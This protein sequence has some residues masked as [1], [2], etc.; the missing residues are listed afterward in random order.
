MSSFLSPP[1]SF[2]RKKRKLGSGTG[3]N[4]ALANVPENRYVGKNLKKIET[5]QEE[6][7]NTSS[8]GED[9]TSKRSTRSSAHSSGEDETSKRSTRSSAHSSGEDETSKRSTRSSVTTQWLNPVSPSSLILAAKLF[10]YNLVLKSSELSGYGIFSSCYGYK[11]G[12]IIYSA[13]CSNTMSMEEYIF[14]VAPTSTPLRHPH[15]FMCTMILG[16]NDTVLNDANRCARWVDL[17]AEYSPAIYINSGEHANIKWV[18]DLTGIPS[19]VLLT[20]SALCE[21]PPDTELLVE[22]YML[23]DE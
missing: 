7:D 8:S 6:V 9:E 3:H 23:V 18:L 15:E 22:A 4:D 5:R 17:K 19:L 16:N 21:I 2:S 11:E 12:E 13:L 10:H 20:I 14:A 1:S